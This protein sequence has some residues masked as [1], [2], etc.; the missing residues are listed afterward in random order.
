MKEASEKD[1]ATSKVRPKR[2]TAYFSME[3]MNPRRHWA[4]VLQVTKD[5]RCQPRL[6]PGKLSTKIEGKG[7]FSIIK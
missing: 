3:T 4:D 2:I 7:K 6:Y 5:H 1:Q